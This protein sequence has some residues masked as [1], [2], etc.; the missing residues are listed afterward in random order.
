[1]RKCSPFVRINGFSSI[2]YFQQFLVHKYYVS[3][4]S[5]DDD[6]D[7]DVILDGA[8]ISEKTD[9]YWHFHTPGV[10]DLLYCPQSITSI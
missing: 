2:K 8:V 4:S 10:E 3:I 6:D 9:F 1:M 7:D 5:D